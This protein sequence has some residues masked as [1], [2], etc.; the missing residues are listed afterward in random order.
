MPVEALK[1]AL[2]MLISLALL[3][4]GSNLVASLVGLQ[5]SRREFPE[6]SL[7]LIAAGFALGGILGANT[8][9][10]AVARVGHLHSFAA[11]AALLACIVLSH[12]L[13]TSPASWMALRLATGI[14]Y[15]GLVLIAESWLNGA[16]DDRSRGKVLGVYML[17]FFASGAAGQLLLGL[18]TDRDFELFV[19]GGMLLALSVVPISLMGHAEAEQEHYEPVPL[20]SLIVEKPLPTFGAFAA[21]IV[22]GTFYALGA[23]YADRQGL[24]TTEVSLFMSLVILG[25]LVFQWPLG[26]LSDWAPRLHVTAAAALATCLC[27]LA[28]TLIEDRTWL[29]SLAFVFGGA[30]FSLYPLN[31]AHACDRVPRGQMVGLSRSFLTILA[32]GAAAGPLFAGVLLTVVGTAIIF[33]LPAAAAAML[34]LTA[35]FQPVLPLFAKRLFVSVPLHSLSGSSLDPRQSARHRRLP[36][37][38]R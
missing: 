24:T 32:A 35:P 10:Q 5:M 38:S 30:A 21:G 2:P 36:K 19:I 11:F 25:A 17:V 28:I 12:A 13:L 8:A 34:V 6:W 33:Y 9:P 18:G 15:Y 7:G 27:G 23:V 22:I 37:S 1:R 3:A 14:F 16:V 31:L 29:F 4:I 26:W 20:S